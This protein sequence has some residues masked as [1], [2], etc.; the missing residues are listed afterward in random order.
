QALQTSHKLTEQHWTI[1]IQQY[2][3][4]LRESHKLHID[5]KRGTSRNP[6]MGIALLVY[7]QIQRWNA[8]EMARI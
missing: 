2:L 7:E 4:I 6:T 3:K 5:T 1:W 8:W